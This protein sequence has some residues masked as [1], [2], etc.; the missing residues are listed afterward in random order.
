MTETTKELTAKAKQVVRVK[1]DSIHRPDGGNLLAVIT[2]A[3]ADPRCNVEKMEALLKMHKE[4][5]AEEARLAFIEDKLRLTDKLPSINKDGKIEFK[6]KGHG[7]A[8]LKFASFENIND[9]IK[10]LLK[11]FSFDLW[12]SSEPGVAGMINVIGNLEHRLGF[13]RKTTFPMPHDGS[14][15]KSGAQGWASAFSFGKRVTTIGLLNIQTKAIEDRDRDGNEGKFVP[16]KGGGF[17]EVPAE[18]PKITAAQRDKI[19]DLITAAKIKESQFCTK[20]GIGQIGMLPA[21]LF[22]AAVKAIADHVEA[23]KAASRG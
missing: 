8:T 18:Q 10:P 9:V 7:A 14:G 5:V 16:A 23:A 6:D 15:G 11:E 2:A 17:A 19:V 13:I 20:Y 12:F 21:E 22:D 4:V 1:A 3:A